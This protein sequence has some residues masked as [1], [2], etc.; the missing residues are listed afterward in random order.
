VG[1]VFEESVASPPV[2]MP[3]D[4]GRDSRFMAEEC[5]RTCGDGR[6]P[7]GKRGKG[8]VK[9][10]RRGIKHALNPADQDFHSSV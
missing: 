9:W 5:S 4:D 3:A 1:I 7:C 8:G 2:R 6:C 10:M